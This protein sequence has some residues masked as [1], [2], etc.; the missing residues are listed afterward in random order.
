MPRTRLLAPGAAAAAAI[1]A[2]V[3]LLWTGMPLALDWYHTHRADRLLSLVEKSDQNSFRQPLD[4]LRVMG[5]PA[6]DAM[7]SVI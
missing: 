6:M 5:P 1:L 2:F 7:I 3:V 4:Q